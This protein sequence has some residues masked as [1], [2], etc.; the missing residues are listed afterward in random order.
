MG[1]AL[2]A[3]TPRRAA[4]VV[5]AMLA[6]TAATAGAWFFG[7]EGAL[8]TATG[9]KTRDPV[10]EN[11]TCESCHLEIAAEWRA[12]QHRSAYT[13]PT[14]QAALAVEPSAFC[15]GCHAPEGPEEDAPEAAQAIG[16]GCVTCH[17]AGDVVIAA[18]RPGLSVAP[19]RVD[20]AEAFATAGACAGCHEFSFGDDTRRD[21]PLAMQAT[22]T[23]H[24]ASDHASRSCADCHMPRTASGHR[25][26]AF[27]ST[28]DPAS[29]RRA[30]V[31][32]AERAGPTSLRLVLTTNGVGHAYPTGDLFRRVSVEA[33]VDGDEF[34]VL[35]SAR[36][37]L[38]RHFTTG[39]DVRDAPIRVEARDDRIGSEP[40]APTIVELDLGVEAEGRPIR[41]SVS[42]DR[43]LHL[44]DHREAAAVVPE[45]VL[46]ASGEVPP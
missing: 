23:E 9:S 2:R 1:R 3:V 35:A 18:P 20:R 29:H 6:A 40:G 32:Q 41:W 38:A 10:E 7:G 15:R 31:A 24:A 26:H 21:A 42:L 34:K 46:L 45:R 33:E 30:V 22:V 36:R 39:R 44:V 28:H 4:A 12:S 37:F 17:L 14:F 19:H 27:A 5:F 11:R 8:P 43:V 16:V 13:D 25:S